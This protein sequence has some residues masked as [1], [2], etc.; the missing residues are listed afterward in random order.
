MNKRERQQEKKSYQKQKSNNMNIISIKKMGEKMNKK[1]N[2][3][4]ISIDIHH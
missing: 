3:K 1:L 2:G 4:I